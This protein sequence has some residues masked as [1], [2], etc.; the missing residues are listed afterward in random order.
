MLSVLYVFSAGILLG[1]GLN[2]LLD[3]SMTYFVRWSGCAAPVMSAEAPALNCPG[4]YVMVNTTIHD[5][6]YWICIANCMRFPM[7]TF[8]LGIS[9]IFVAIIELFKGKTHGHDDVHMH[10]LVKNDAD[11]SEEVPN[12]CGAMIFLVVL[13]IPSFL[14]GLGL[15]VD[16]F[17][18]NDRGIGIF[19]AIF[20]IQGF[21]A[22]ALGANFAKEIDKKTMSRTL[23]IVIMA[24]FCILTPIGAILGGVLSGILSGSTLKLFQGVV[25]ALTTGTFIYV[26]LVEMFVEDFF[27][28]RSTN[29]K[30]NYLKIIAHSISVYAGYV[31]MSLFATY[32]G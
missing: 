17:Q 16:T 29:G 5:E 21:E 25:L 15:G 2:H 12:C 3:D 18:S 11:E 13:S 31:G 27:G 6:N 24:I 28:Q 19:I 7:T 1:A 20:S 14:E 30:T 26:G 10:S 4:G 32:F 23:A 22:F 9:L 8:L